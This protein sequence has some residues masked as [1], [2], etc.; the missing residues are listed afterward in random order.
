MLRLG[1]APGKLYRATFIC[2]DGLCCCNMA[3]ISFRLFRKNLGN[4][5]DFFGQMIYR[6]PWQ[7]ISRTP[8]DNCTGCNLSQCRRSGGSVD[9]IILVST[10]WP[11]IRNAPDSVQRVRCNSCWCETYILYVLPGFFCVA[12]LKIAVL[13]GLNNILL[14]LCIVQANCKLRF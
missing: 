3:L 13:K 1:I 10:E 7:K 14:Q 12:F 9:K 4:L 11:L 2:Q 8:M 5:R 6:P